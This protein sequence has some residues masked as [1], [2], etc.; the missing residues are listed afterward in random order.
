MFQ[1]F[2]GELENWTDRA[3]NR[4]TC[5]AY[6]EGDIRA[7]T[8]EEYCICHLTLLWVFNSTKRSRKQRKF[9]AISL[10]SGPVAFYPWD[11]I[12]LFNLGT[13]GF[14]IEKQTANRDHSPSLAFGS[15]C[16]DERSRDRGIYISP[17]LSAQLPRVIHSP[18]ILNGKFRRQL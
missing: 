12:S 4:A 11:V 9:G 7:I 8:E 3:Q 6:F 5:T 14:L 18:K 2:L 16:S 10:I 15:H 13:L 17:H 1:R